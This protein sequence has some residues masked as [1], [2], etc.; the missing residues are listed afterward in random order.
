MKKFLFIQIIFLGLLSCGVR[1]KS[2]EVRLSRQ[3]SLLSWTWDELT[4]MHNKYDST[5]MKRTESQV[6]YYTRGHKQIRGQRVDSLSV[7]TKE[8]HRFS[9]STRFRWSL[10]LFVLG[11]VLGIWLSCYWR[12]LKGRS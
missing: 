7:K 6:L 11:L 12:R 1:K 4:V 10:W 2:S 9:G 8:P 5:G 3:D